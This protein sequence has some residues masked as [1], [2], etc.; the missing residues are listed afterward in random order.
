MRPELRHG[1]RIP[2]THSLTG[3]LLRAQ[4]PVPLR[5]RGGGGGGF[6]RDGAHVSTP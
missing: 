6:R 2:G 1:P 5:T 3:P 4:G